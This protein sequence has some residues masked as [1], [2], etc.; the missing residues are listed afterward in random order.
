MPEHTVGNGR[1]P[2]GQVDHRQRSAVIK[3]TV[4]DGRNRLGN[5]DF[6]QA[7]T[8]FKSIIADALQP[9]GQLDAL[10]AAA[11]EHA[12][13]NALELGGQLHGLQTGGAAEAMVQ[14]LRGRFREDDPGQ[15]LAVGKSAVVDEDHTVGDLHLLKTGSGEAI[16]GDP[17]Q[18]FGQVD[19]GQRLAIAEASG[20]HRLDAVMELYLGQT[21]TAIKEPLRQLRDTGRDGDGL[22][23][24]CGKGTIPQGVQ[25]FREF[26]FGQRL[27]ACEGIRTDD[28]QPLAQLHIC[29]CS[30]HQK[31]IGSDLRDAVRQRDG[32]AGTQIAQQL[33]ADPG[34][35]RLH[36]HGPDV[37]PFRIP[38]RIFRSAILIGRAG[39]GNGQHL[40][41]QGPGHIFAAAARRG[42][43]RH[44]H[45]RQ[46]HANHD[47]P[48]E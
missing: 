23:A 22:Q 32:R 39:T 2:F 8:V 26:Q 7:L 21:S 6:F 43:G 3:S 11:G 35:A 5:D 12:I 36:D 46:D 10:D 9:I 17:I 41:I 16:A 27:T 4:A 28:L 25:T 38:G 47:G 20:P 29:Q 34:D 24:A 37:G 33:L 44:G 13:G 1:Q 42:L 15:T 48:A 40:L 31:C 19:A 30:T 18:A 45:H 14:Q